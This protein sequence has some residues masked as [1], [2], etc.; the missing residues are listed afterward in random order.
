MF[1]KAALS[2]VAA[3][4]QVP[5]LNDRKRRSRCEQCFESRRLTQLA[6]T[7]S[8]AVIHFF[9]Q[10]CYRSGQAFFEGIMRVPGQ[11]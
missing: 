11:L 4:A 6:K 8:H 9:V 5:F 10:N 2:A 3:G 7:R 1:R